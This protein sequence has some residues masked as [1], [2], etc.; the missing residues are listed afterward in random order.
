[1]ENQCDVEH[2]NNTLRVPLVGAWSGDR[3]SGEVLFSHPLVARQ[4]G[5]FPWWVTPSLQYETPQIL[6]LGW[7]APDSPVCGLWQIEGRGYSIE[8]DFVLAGSAG[9]IIRIRG[10]QVPNK[11]KIRIAL[12][13]EAPTNVFMASTKTASK[14]LRLLHGEGS[15]CVELS[16]TS[17]NAVGL[18]A[19]VGQAW[20]LTLGPSSVGLQTLAR[21][22]G[23]EWQAAI[24]SGEQVCEMAAGAVRAGSKFSVAHLSTAGQLRGLLLMETSHVRVH[25]KTV[26]ESGTAK[27][28]CWTP[29]AGVCLLGEP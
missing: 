6:T 25:G 19:P 14:Q 16:T 17:P 26:W 24:S 21:R 12:A 27:T 8:L 9:C 3:W 10:L 23:A 13:D 2:G 28:V 5:R 15:S 20:K 29:R 11:T 4:P 18:L 1:V 22:E 7:A